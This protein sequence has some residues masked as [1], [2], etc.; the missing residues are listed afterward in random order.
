MPPKARN[1][2]EANANERPRLRNTPEPARAPRLALPM[3]RSKPL[4]DL[5]AV[6]NDRWIDVASPTILTIS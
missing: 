3:S 1:P 4:V 5:E 2:P 6:E